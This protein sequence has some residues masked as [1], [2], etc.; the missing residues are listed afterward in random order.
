MA[1]E[2]C[3]GDARLPSCDAP[4]LLRLSF[5][6]AFVGSHLIS[7][8]GEQVDG[9]Q[10]NQLTVFRGEGKRGHVTLRVS[11][12]SASATKRFMEQK[13]P[14]ARTL[15]SRGGKIIERREIGGEGDSVT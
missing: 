15:R 2:H 6:S 10:L 14:R 1:H 5:D 7:Y 9:K 4:T 3:F 11:E 8:T 12:S 13:N